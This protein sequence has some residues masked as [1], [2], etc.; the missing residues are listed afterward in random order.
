MDTKSIFLDLAR[1]TECMH[2]H[3]VC[4]SCVKVGLEMKILLS[5]NRLFLRSAQ[6]TRWQHKKQFKEAKRC[7]HLYRDGIRAIEEAHYRQCQRAPEVRVVFHF[8]R[9][10]QI[11]RQVLVFF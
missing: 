6:L 1:R 5:F 11:R 3:L 10:A 4:R 2:E 7:K 8:K 9:F